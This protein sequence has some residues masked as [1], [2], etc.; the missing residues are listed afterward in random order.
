MDERFDFNLLTIFLEVYQLRSITLAADSLGLTQP[1]VSQALKRL[2]IKLGVDLFVREGRGISPTN[3]AAQLANQISPAFK[4]MNSALRNVVGFDKKIPRSFLVYINEPMM[5]LLQP[6]VE[7]DLS[8]GNCNIKFQVTPDNENQ[9]LQQLSLQKADLA[10]DFG[11]LPNLSFSN[12]FFYNEEIV[13]VCRKGHPRID[14]YITQEQF[15]QEKHITLKMR[16]LNLS[17]LDYFTE[18][19]IH[20]RQVSCECQSIVSMMMMIS[21]TNCIGVTSSGMADKY[22]EKLNLQRIQLPFKTIPVIHKLIWHKRNEF[23][24]AH[25]W[26]REKLTGLISL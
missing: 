25:I 15:N 8:M 13:L 23:D 10:I 26:L 17:A 21:E 20:E 11:P 2:Q 16:R 14:G 19:I 18:G 24:P 12:Q 1:G 6:A 5:N 3:A 9:L 22:A 4:M 7:N